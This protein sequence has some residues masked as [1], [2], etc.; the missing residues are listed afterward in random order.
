MSGPT[1]APVKAALKTLWAGTSWPATPGSEPMQVTYGPRVTLVS[2]RRLTIGKV[3]GDTS[4][5]ALGPQRTMEEEYDIECSI[6]YTIN[7][8]IDDQQAVTEQVIAD[9]AVAELAVRSSVGQ[10]LGVPG[11]LWA[12]VMGSW[13]IDEATAS[14]TGGPI[15]ASYQFR[16]HVRA[17]YQLG[18]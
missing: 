17:R 3:L 4:P 7:G 14:E 18:A 6:S 12:L 9:Q 16:V 13:E 15:N 2:G 1:A 10:T 5:E 8:T 11:V